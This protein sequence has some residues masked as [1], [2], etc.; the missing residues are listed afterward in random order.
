MA[1]N[2]RIASAKQTPSQPSRWWQWILLYPALGISLVTSVP[3]WAD[4]A[5]AKYNGVKSDKYSDALRQTEL[6][7]NNLAC[8][9]APTKYSPNVNN[10]NVDATICKKTGD[11]FVQVQTPDKRSVKHW[12]DLE[13][14]LLEDK[15]RAAAL[16]SS[17]QAAV[18]ARGISDDPR[19]STGV[20]GEDGNLQLAQ[21]SN[22]SSM[23]VC[24]K[25]VDPR[26]LLRHIRTP[27]GCF[28]EII[29]TLNGV[30]VRQTGVP[31][32]GSC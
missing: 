24:Q 19:I 18:P 16:I 8:L 6:W 4:K 31:C 9:V 14:I 27:Q 25:F 11:I 23:V 30:V 2:A 32:R 26:Y 28:D 3:E 12:V 1:T 22:G 20:A 21:A 13:R 17:A 29:D 7:K 15:P 10:V 5:L